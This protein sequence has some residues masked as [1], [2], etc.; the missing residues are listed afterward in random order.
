MQT[1]RYRKQMTF[2]GLG[3]NGQEALGRS[4]VFVAGCGATGGTMAM[5]LVRAGVGR[6]TVVDRDIPEIGNIHRQLLYKEKDPAGEIPKA[7]L[8]EKRLRKMNSEVDVRGIAADINHENIMELLDGADLIMDGVDNQE[9]RYLLNDAAFSLNIPWIHLGVIGSAGNIMP[10]IP[11]KTPCL[12]C[13]FP[14]PAPPGTLPTCDS[15]GILGP[16]PAVAASIAAAEAMKVLAGIPL[17]DPPK[18]ISFDLWM[19]SFR[20]SSFPR[21]RDKNCPCCGLGRRDFLNPS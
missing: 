13:I 6:V 7:V 9:T 20:E 12:R 16:T 10:I 11:E 14:E 2:K 8:A 3:A 17:P 15:A 19:S 5:L 1:E 4:S 21:G 18:L